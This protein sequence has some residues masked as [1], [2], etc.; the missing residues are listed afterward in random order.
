MDWFNQTK[1]DFDPDSVQEKDEKE[2]DCQ[3]IT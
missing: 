3:F 2:K 1:R